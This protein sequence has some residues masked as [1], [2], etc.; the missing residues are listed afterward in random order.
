[1]SIFPYSN[2]YV[3]YLKDKIKNAT[4]RPKMFLIIWVKSTCIWFD[5]SPKKDTRIRKEG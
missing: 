1:M 5:M 2:A 3:H 4:Y